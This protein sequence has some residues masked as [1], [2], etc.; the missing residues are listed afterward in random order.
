MIRSGRARQRDVP[1]LTIV[2]VVI[3]VVAVVVLLWQHGGRFVQSATPHG[4]TYRTEG[5]AATTT[6][7]FRSP[8]GTKR[9]TGDII[10]LTTAA[11]SSIGRHFTMYTGTPL[12]LSITNE[13]GAGSVTCVIDADG[14]ELD[15]QTSTD[16]FGTV[17]CHSSLP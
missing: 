10:P 4:V 5:T 11:D 6:V 17:T 7:V 15:R 13:T 9:E 1:L 3:A 2:T 12:S 16:P 14:T 8:T